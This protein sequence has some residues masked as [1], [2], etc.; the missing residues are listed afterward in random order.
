MRFITATVL[1][2]IATMLGVAVLVLAWVLTTEAGLRFTLQQM[3]SLLPKRFAVGAVD[4][5]LIGPL[6]LRNLDLKTET[7]RLTAKYVNFDWSPSRLLFGEVVIDR[8]HV[9]DASLTA[10]KSTTP[11]ESTRTPAEQL[12]LLQPPPAIELNDIALQNFEYRAPGSKPFVIRHAELAAA[13]D[14]SGLHID[15]LQATGPL[16]AIQGHAIIKPQSGHPTQGEL[17][18]QVRL[19][20]YPT[21]VGHT[22]LSGSLRELHVGQRIEAPYRTQATVV[23]HDALT[24]PYFQ[25]EVQLNAIKLQAV[26]ADLPNVTVNATAHAKGRASAMEYTAQAKVIDPAQGTFKLDLDGGLEKQVVDIQRLTLMVVDTPTRLHAN[27][28]V[29]LSSKQPTLN[30]KADWQK[31]RWPLQGEPRFTSPRGNLAI[32]GTPKDL[33]AR[34]NAAVGDAGG[35]NGRVRREQDNIELALDWHDLSWPLHQPRV[36]SPQ[37]TARVTGTLQHYALAVNA[38]VDM[39]DQAGGHVILE[40]TGSNKSLDL[41][42]IELQALQGEIN[43]SASVAW[44]PQLDGRISLN[45]NGINPGVLLPDWPGKLA[46]RLQASGAR[47]AGKLTAQLTALDVTGRLRGQNFALNAR[48]DYHGDELQLERMSLISGSSTVQVSGKVGPTLDVNWRIDS[49]NLATLLPGAAGSLHGKGQAYGELRRPRI[50]ASLDGKNVRYTQYEVGQL[51]FQADVDMQGKVQSSIELQLQDGQAA[52][53]ELSKVSF[54][55]HGTPQAHQF[56]LAAH[57]STG[58]AEL[59]LDGG[60]QESIWSFELTKARL[61]YPTLPAWILAEPAQGRVSAHAQE[62]DRTCWTSTEAKLCVRGQRSSAGLQAAFQLDG[63][64]FEYFAALMPTN[65]GI[66]GKMSGHGEVRQPSGGLL[67]ADVKLDTTAGEILATTDESTTQAPVLRFKPAELRVDMGTQGLEL[68]IDLPFVDQGGFRMNAQIPPGEAPLTARPVSG[69]IRVDVRDIGFLAKLT[70]DV[71]HIG[72]QLRGRMRISGT[73]ARPALLGRL[74]LLDGSARLTGPGLNITQLSAQLVG[75]PDGGLS[76]SVHAK[77]GGGTLRLAGT[78]D[79]T[80]KTPRA[81]MRIDGQDF[82]A[83]NTTEARVFISPALQISLNAGGITVNGEVRVPR[84]DITPK[85]IPP[86][87]V[88]VSEDQVIIEPHQGEKPKAAEARKLHARVRLILGDQVRFEG[89]GLKGR[90]EGQLLIIQQPDDPTRGSGELRIVEGEYRAYG[91][92]LVIETGRILFAGGPITQPGIDI[93]AVRHPAEGITVGVQ[94]RGT[95]KEPKLTIFSEPSMTQAEQLSWLVLGRPLQGASSS[96]A[97][98]LSQAALALGLKGGDFLVKKFGKNLGVDTIGIETGSGEAGAA[99]DVNAAALVIG[100]YLSPGLYVS[101]GIG[102]FDQVSTVRL[103]YT[104]S[105]HWKLATESSTEASGGDVI[106]TIER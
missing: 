64:P 78:A 33:T 81:E 104:L 74:A 53:V 59:R 31:L 7:S 92:G 57:T 12:A 25:A 13:A 82:Q 30:L 14:T 23:L 27:G 34:L 67:A 41:A 56:D 36:S 9:R 77:S 87:A 16:F 21:A 5:R 61:K 72:G 52:G 70:P 106:Y 84:A 71:E 51:A 32:T 1:S 10:Y 50:K 43:G 49:D 62:L 66:T 38:R 76:Y 63:L 4:G 93:R 55:G 37:G 83:F 105:S 94:V 103:Q 17:N 6:T 91:Q 73:L 68:S 22:T 86:S 80:G 54:T 90:I 39:P 45:G 100:K 40:G 98:M 60:L 3:H 69:Q 48:G 79:L 85:K 19:P 35:I 29:D 46:L 8:L 18:W 89:F 44:Q 47:Q 95:L 99:S 97:A 65:I 88:T 101:Y 75:E 96:E 15:K 28:R 58:D 11:E 102:L 26:R 2:L 42:R 24:D 20:D